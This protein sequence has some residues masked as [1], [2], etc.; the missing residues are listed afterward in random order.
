M[1]FL[2]KLVYNLIVNKV[3]VNNMGHCSDI[4]VVNKKS[5][6]M[7]EAQDYAWRNADH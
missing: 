5:D 2:L 4:L 3:E 7:A 1:Y 6:I